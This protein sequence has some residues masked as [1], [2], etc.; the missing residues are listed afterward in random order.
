MRF[1]VMHKVEAAMES[2]AT[3]SKDIVEK[4]LVGESLKS[5]IFKD[6]EGLH[7]SARLRHRGGDRK[8]N[9][10]TAKAQARQA[11]SA[12]YINPPAAIAVRH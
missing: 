1:I 9:R 2:G 11:P 7:R 8:V 12:V 3:P 4:K 6:G 5:G 10:T